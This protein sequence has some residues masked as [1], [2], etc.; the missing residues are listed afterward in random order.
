MS[1]AELIFL[2]LLIAVRT[3]FGVTA[4]SSFHVSTH[5]ATGA[6]GLPGG[7]SES[8]RRLNTASSSTSVSPGEDLRSLFKTN[9]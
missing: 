1:G 3:S 9:L 2:L 4:N 8:K 7:K 5:Q 6:R